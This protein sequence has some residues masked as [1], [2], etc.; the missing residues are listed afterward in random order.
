MLSSYGNNRLLRRV[1]EA[2]FRHQKLFWIS[3]IGISGIVSMALLLRGNSYTAAASTRISSDKEISD[4]LGFDKQIISSPAQTN[5]DRFNDLLKDDTPGGFMD[6]ALTAAKLRVPINVDPR[7][8]DKRL[9]LLR[10][11]MT[12]AVD[13]SEVFRIQ[14][15]WD[16]AGECE[17]IVQAFQDSYIEEAGTV[18]QATALAT[19]RF[20]DSQ[21]Q[22]YLKRMRVA[23][24]ALIEYK[25]KFSGNLPEAQTSE[26]ARLAE[27]KKER[28]GLLISSRDNEL[29][30]QTVAVTTG[31]TQ[32]HDGRAASFRG[33]GKFLP[34]Y[35]AECGRPRR[36]AGFALPC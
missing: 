6:R 14:L 5:V 10:K 17:R 28:D 26:I 20:L 32:A 15:T 16:D 8:R 9:E 25:E 4:V 27:L 36:A 19:T 30:K 21:I 3:A 33:S 35:R 24:Q 31:A 18:R 13:S 34:G 12:V 7:Y 1:L 22:A 23:E 29:R 2:F 11:K